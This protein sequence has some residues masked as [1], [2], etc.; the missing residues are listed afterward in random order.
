MVTSVMSRSSSIVLSQRSSAFGASASK[1]TTNRSWLTS[2]SISA[3]L[4]TRKVSSL[5]VELIHGHGRQRGSSVVLG[6]ILVNLV[7]RDSGV[8]NG[9]LNSLL[10]D[11][12]LNVLVDVVVDVLASNRWCSCAGVLGLTDFAAVLELSG[13]SSETVLD[14]RVVAVLDVAVLNTCHLVAV[15]LGKDLTV[16]DGLDGCVVVILVDLTVYCGG[17]I[18]VS[19][20]SDM[21]VLDGG[22]DRLVDS[23]VVLSIL[24]KEVSNCCLC[25]F[26]FDLCADNLV[27][28]CSS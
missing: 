6:L 15:L 27:L 8:N 7:D 23:G 13:L 26:H 16:L 12:W 1:G 5:S 10:L 18:L 17:H 2:K 11:D 22:V 25:L 21:L 20:G 24:G 3:L 14:V 9:W 4:T 19:G 28:E